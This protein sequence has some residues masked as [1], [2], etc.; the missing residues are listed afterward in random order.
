MKKAYTKNDVF[1]LLESGNKTFKPELYQ[2]I[3]SSEE[4]KNY[5]IESLKKSEKE[6]EKVFYAV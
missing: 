4:Y 3:I 1:K 6:F 5:E 2:T